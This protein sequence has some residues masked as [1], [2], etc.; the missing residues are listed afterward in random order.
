MTLKRPRYCGAFFFV[1]NVPAVGLIF[2]RIF[3]YFLIHQIRDSSLFFK[4]GMFDAGRL[5]EFD[6]LLRARDFANSGVFIELN[7]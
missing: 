4:A 7:F 2:T 3:L 1:E 6:I 5:M